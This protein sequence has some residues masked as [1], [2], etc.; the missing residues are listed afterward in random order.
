MDTPYFVEPATRG[1]YRPTTYFIKTAR[2]GVLC[3]VDDVVF[4]HKLVDLLNAEVRANSSVGKRRK[5]R[6]EYGSACSPGP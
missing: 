3:S 5:R 2:D 4:A 6:A 1:P